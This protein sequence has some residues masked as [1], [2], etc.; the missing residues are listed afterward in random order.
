M[1]YVVITWIAVTM[2]LITHGHSATFAERCEGIWQG[3]MM[4]WAQG[5]LVDSVTVKLTV[6]QVSDSSKTWIW[7]TEYLSTQHPVIKDYK[8]IQI[9]D[10]ATQYDFDEGE[11]VIIRNY[12]F[13]SKMYSFFRVDKVS[14]SAY[15]ELVDDKLV[16]EVTSGSK[17][18]VKSK[19]VINYTCDYVQRVEFKRLS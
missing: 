19:E 10:Q 16:F 5:R 18:K 17:S 9:N 4:I 12:I 13:G 2:S 3:N 7:K 14:L 6:Q 15:Y 11:G 8:L 1:K